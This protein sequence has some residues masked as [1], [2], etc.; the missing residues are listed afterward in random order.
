MTRDRTVGVLSGRSLSGEIVHKGVCFYSLNDI[1]RMYGVNAWS[2]RYQ[3]SVRR[4]NPENDCKSDCELVKESIAE[5]VK[6]ELERAKV[7]IK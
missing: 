2:L 1:A 7:T 5:L 6:R 3:L 4:D